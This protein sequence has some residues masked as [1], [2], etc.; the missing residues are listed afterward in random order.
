MIS[1]I[2]SVYNGE[3][4][5][6]LAIESILNQTYPHLEFIVVDDASTDGTPDLLSEFQSLDQRLLIT[7]NPC[8]Q[9]LTKSLNRAISLAKGDWIARQDAD[10]ISLPD[11][12]QKQLAFMETHPEV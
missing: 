12:F 8:R 2:M 6:A 9:G 1:V 7:R 3:K 4:Y 11:R 5:L 10:D